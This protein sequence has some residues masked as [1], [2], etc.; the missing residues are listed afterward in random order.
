M[1]CF[2]FFHHNSAKIDP[3]LNLTESS[4]SS[5][6]SDLGCVSHPLACTLCGS[7]DAFRP[8]KRS[9]AIVFT[10]GVSLGQSALGTS[11][12]ATNHFRTPSVRYTTIA[13]NEPYWT[14]RIA[15]AARLVSNF[16]AR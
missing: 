11:G 1:I 3:S 9:P 5:Y 6:H 13:G 7:R 10:E 2:S 4:M 12:P 15:V 14:K 16:V 8:R